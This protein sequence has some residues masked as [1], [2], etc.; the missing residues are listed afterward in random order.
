MLRPPA[1]VDGLRMVSTSP[2]EVQMEMVTVSWGVGQEIVTYGPHVLWRPRSVRGAT[3][4]YEN[5]IFIGWIFNQSLP[6]FFCP[7]FCQ[8][9]CQLFCQVSSLHAECLL[10]GGPCGGMK[11]SWEWGID[12][13]L[14]HGLPHSYSCGLPFLGPQSGAHRLSATAVVQVGHTA[15]FFFCFSGHS[16]TCCSD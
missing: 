1:G 10:S 11:L 15:C 9:F 13:A 4:S 14:P 5:Q 12:P 7:M 3:T 16:T 6:K 2:G 8:L